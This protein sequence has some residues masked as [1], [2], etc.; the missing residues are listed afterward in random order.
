[1]KLHVE[2][3]VDFLLFDNELMS[4][5]KLYGAHGEEPNEDHQL[6]TQLRMHHK[7]A[8]YPPDMSQPPQHCK[9]CCRSP[10]VDILPIRQ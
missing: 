6:V 9:K 5:T 3:V 2:D 1:M 4:A 7:F 8:A 10:A